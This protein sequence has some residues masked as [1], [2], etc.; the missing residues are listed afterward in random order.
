MASDDGDYFTTAFFALQKALLNWPAMPP[1]AVLRDLPGTWS[2]DWHRG[3][4]AQAELGLDLV[5]PNTECELG[6]GFWDRITDGAWR[7]TAK[8]G[9]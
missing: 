4:R 6:A 7:T 5:P 8:P 1:A 3:K 2:R 9:A